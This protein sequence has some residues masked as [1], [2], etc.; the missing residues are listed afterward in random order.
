MLGTNDLK[1]MYNRTP[2]RIALGA[3]HLIDLVNTLDGGVGTTYQNPK[4]L[5]VCPPP[6]N[7]KMKSRADLWADV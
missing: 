5:L 1:A 4:V 7:E 3:G 6:L 2:F